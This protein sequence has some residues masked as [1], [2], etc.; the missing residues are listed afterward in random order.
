VAETSTST[1]SPLQTI[2]LPILLGS[3]AF[4]FL[5]FALPISGRRLGASAVQIGG[6]FSIWAL[7]VAVI[8]PLVG[9]GLDRFGRKLFFV[10]ASLFFTASLVVFGLAQGL[11]GL[12]GGQLLRGLGSSMMWISAYTIATD[13][14]GSNS[15]GGAVGRVDEASARGQL[16]GGIGGFVLFSLLPENV[17][18]YVIFGGYTVLAALGAYLGWKHVPET[19][20]REILVGAKEKRLSK[21]LYKLMA[22]VFVTAA[23]RS[24]IRPIFLIFLQDRFAPSI[25]A[26]VLAIIP[27]GIVAGFLPSRLGKLSDRFGRTGLMGVGLLA[28]GVL[29]FFLPSLPSLIW[30]A[31]LWTIETVGWSVAAPAEE[32]MVADL[33]GKRVRGRG[34]GLYTLATSLGA[35]AGPLMGGWVYDAIGEQVPFYL[36]GIVL[37]C[38]AILVPILLRRPKSSPQPG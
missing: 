4:V 10:T 31:L 27:A 1:K 24:M 23:S 35:F 28:S 30:L 36:N 16:Y 33:T 13:I 22:I 15:R 32:A 38:G 3:L 18:W 6:L 29:S 12:F 14:S 21:D 9:I 37:L 19:K 2:H 20:P 7:A 5:E 34:Y 8:R 26:L 17:S 25:F 11:L